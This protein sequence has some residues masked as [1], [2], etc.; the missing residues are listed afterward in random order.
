MNKGLFLVVL[1][2]AGA[3][4][5]G[6]YLVGTSVKAEPSLDV[7][8]A[9]TPAGSSPD[10]APEAALSVEGPAPGL[11]GNEQLSAL[12]SAL[13][14]F[15]DA[16]PERG[17]GEITGIVLTDAGK[18]LAGVEVSSLPQR[19]YVQPER[20][21]DPE[22][23]LLQGIQRQIE[24]A[25]WSEANRVETTT[26]G[27]GRFVLE[28]LKDREHRVYA[29][30]EGW[31]ISSKGTSTHKAKPGDE[32]R[33]EATAVTGV[34]LEVYGPDGTMPKSASVRFES[35]SGS[36]SSSWQPGR[37]T[38]EVEPG[39]YEMSVTAG[40]YREMRSE[41]VS[42]EVEKGQAVTIRVDLVASP[43]LKLRLGFPDGE[44][45]GS[46]GMGGQIFRMRL[47]SNEAPKASALQARGQQEWASQR[48]SDEWIRTF[49]DV[50]PGYY[51]IGYSRGHNYPIETIDVVEVGPGLTEHTLEVPPLEEDEYVVL[52]IRGPD[53]EP[54]ANASIGTGY[55]SD[56]SSSS[57]SSPLVN[58]GDGEYWVMH[59]RHGWRESDKG[60]YWI[61]AT[62]K[63]YGTK[64][65]EYV[66]GRTHLLKID[67]EPP[68]S[69]DVL[70]KG[71]AGSDYEGSTKIFL[72][73]GK[74]TSTGQTSCDS[75]GKARIDGIQPGE[76]DLKIVIGVD[77]W[78]APVHTETIR[79]KPG[80]NSIVTELPP[81]YSVTV[82][83]AEGYAWV[84]R[85]EREGTPS[86]FHKN[87]QSAEGEAVFDGLPAG[88]YTAQSG[89]KQ[90]TFRVPG[91]R[92]V[93]LE[94]PPS[95]G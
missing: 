41:P 16:V 40:E 28:G 7:G 43:V 11:E 73:Q 8:V 30:L 21:D 29:K 68:A 88:E 22:E 57:G 61:A 90:A 17:D 4:F 74:H 48:R 93:V 12:R 71:V 15:P 18:P 46:T 26:D 58:R 35:G 89:S 2:V 24:N 77:H 39:R 60:T 65:V 76:Y 9:T 94:E 52:L 47:A 32:L 54:I 62:T 63:N 82:R 20:P 53:G 78:G 83:G 69:A 36:R 87:V 33:F 66:P 86:H 67:F 84:Q 49:T 81:L 70:V 3:A 19:E 79:L 27:E 80:T 23:A 85:V 42:I 45:M 25:R 64:R 51:A 13:A 95:G 1:V 50:E 38:V 56:S 14:A 37:K 91:A 72:F 6:G 5:G 75:E 59:H 44:S 34:T 31:R 92:I 10:R 55:V